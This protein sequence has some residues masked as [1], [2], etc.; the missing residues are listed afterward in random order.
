MAKFITKETKPGKGIP[1]NAPEKR[2]FFQF[3]EVLGAK[4]TKLM[5]LNFIYLI[6]LIP[7]ILGLYFSFKINTDNSN[8]PLLV[9]RADYINVSILALSLFLTGPA[10]A[11]FVYV[12][13]NM[14][15]REHAWIF[16]DFWT[17]FKKNY[18]QG[19]AMSVLDAVC[20]FLLYVAY[21]FYGYIMPVSMP[22]SD[23]MSVAGVAFVIILTVVYTWSHYYIYTM[24]VTFELKFSVLFKN[25]MIFAIA[26][27]PLNILITLIVGGIVYLYLLLMAYSIAAFSI[28]F[29]LIG[30]SL[31]WLIIVFGTYPTIDKLMLKKAKEKKRILNTRDGF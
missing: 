24:M 5:Q 4:F 25:S 8:M 19:L 1:V 2:R 28:V 11:G 27:L 18:K 21:A 20:Y 15:R 26:K 30:I 23:F 29:A 13:R 3:F 31:L 6:F 9:F 7:L 16:S 14:Q 17:Q 22:G 12:I 10:T